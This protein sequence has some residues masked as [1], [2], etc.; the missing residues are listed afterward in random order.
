MLCSELLI[1]IDFS[2][3]FV[4][5]YKLALC[6]IEAYQ[7]ISELSHQKSLNDFVLV[8]SECMQ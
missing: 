1:K 6:K 8:C 5:N 7:F 3:L 2:L 4:N